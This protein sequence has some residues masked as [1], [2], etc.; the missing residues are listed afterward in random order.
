MMKLTNQS[1]D[2]LNKTNHN[3]AITALDGTK[4]AAVS[5]DSTSSSLNKSSGKLD[6]ERLARWA[7]LAL[8]Q[9]KH[10][11]AQS[12]E[13]KLIA[14]YRELSVISRAVNAK[15]RNPQQQADNLTQLQRTVSQDLNNALQPK[16]LSKHPE[17][18]QFILNS[19][20]LF[21]VK[22]AETINLVLPA[23]GKAVS[24]HI[25]EGAATDEVVAI[26]A[27][28]VAPLNIQ[29]ATNANKQLVF[30]IAVGQSRTL[31]EPVLFSGEGIRIPAG[32]PVPV[33]LQSQ[34]NDLAELADLV[35][36]DNGADISATISQMQSEVK[37]SLAKLRFIMSKIQQESARVATSANIEQVQSELESLLRQG[38]FG[39]RLT[40]LLA[41]ANISRDTAVSL[42]TI[43]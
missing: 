41:Q 26:V 29:V 22:P 43:R 12:A 38:D 8:V 37:R 11:Q 13:R 25:P 21:S 16:M 3:S 14:V 28:A 34:K 19:V 9:K 33:Q 39:S 15:V 18:S 40:G 6:A 20:D 23:A 27:K 5:S 7:S 4:T 30:N 32:N 31:S 35:K 17:Q 2:G 36:Q 42:L 1:I 10:A 24:F